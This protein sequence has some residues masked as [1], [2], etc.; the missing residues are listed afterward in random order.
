M[1]RDES[2]TSHKESRSLI[3]SEM[4]CLACLMQ[5]YIITNLYSQLV[6][7]RGKVLI[8]EYTAEFSTSCAGP[9]PPG[10]GPVPR[11]VPRPVRAGPQRRPQARAHD[12]P[13]PLRAPGCP[14]LGV[15]RGATA[16]LCASASSAAC[17][18]SAT[19]NA[20]GMARHRDCAGHP[21]S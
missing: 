3:R 20:H 11:P 21:A 5:K 2:L 4:G 10:R 14:P 1:F 19:W 6:L 8:T 12:S 13:L 16:E 15:S 17:S 9:S 7:S 18:A